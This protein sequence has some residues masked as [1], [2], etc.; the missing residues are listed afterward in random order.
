VAAW[1]ER[2]HQPAAAPVT[3]PRNRPVPAQPGPAQ[4]HRPAAQRT[5]QKDL[6]LS[7]AS[8]DLRRVC[9]GDQLRPPPIADV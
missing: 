6:A 8:K 4:R 1:L 9:C 5:A 3:A 2:K 7:N